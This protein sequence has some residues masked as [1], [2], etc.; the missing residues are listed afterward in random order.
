MAPTRTELTG[1][2]IHLDVGAIQSSFHGGGAQ[3]PLGEFICE[4]T[5]VFM[6]HNIKERHREIGLRCVE[7]VNPEHAATIGKEAYVAYFLDAKNAGKEPAG[8][9]KGLLEEV[10]PVCTAPQF[11]VQQEG[12][13]GLVPFNWLKGAKV[14]VATAPE[15]AK[16][17][18]QDGSIETFTVNR[19][20]KESIQLVEVSP[21]TKDILTKAGLPADTKVVP[22]THPPQHHLLPQQFSSQPQGQAAAQQQA[23]NAAAAQ[24]GNNAGQLPPPQL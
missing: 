20:Q 9:W 23:A 12:K 1:L 6:N 17:K 22:P 14:R 15:E 16:R 3:W 8:W 10:A 7:A 2:D 5:G 19:V 13:A 18:N 24:G 4:V 11:M 21:F